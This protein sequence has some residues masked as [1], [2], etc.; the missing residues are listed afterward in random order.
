MVSGMKI[1]AWATV[2]WIAGLLTGGTALAANVSRSGDVTFHKDVLPILQKNC[3]N[4]HRPGQI[5][6]MPLLTYDE[7]RPWAKAIKAAVL[8]H[9][10]P[11][12]FADPQYGHFSNDRTLKPQE[13]ATLVKWVDGGAVAGDPKDAPAPVAWP[14]EGWRIKPDH[15]VKGVAYHVPKSGV[16]PWMYVTV[17]VGFNE[18]TWVTSMEM[19]PGSKPALTHH[20]CIFLVPHRD[21]VQYGVFNETGMLGQAAAT[22]NAPF[23]GCYEKGQEEFDYRPQHAGRLIPANM[24]MVFQMHYQPNGEEAIDLPQV[25][26]TV[27][28]ERP[29]RQYVFFNVGAGLRL[30]IPPNEANYIAPAQE[31]EL[32]VDGE[33]VWLQ[34]HA[35][36]RAKEMKFDILYPDGR[37]ETALRVNW[38]PYW[39]TIYYPS[40]PIVVPK[41]TRLH[42]EGRYDN[43]ANNPYNPDPNA[44]VHFGDQGKDEMMF[45][46]FGVIVDGS[47]DLTK[48]QVLKP[49]PRAG[50]DFII[51]ES[52]SSQ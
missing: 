44:L 23:E 4:C 42:I 31:G 5:G 7:T 45:P 48:T 52:A 3:Q 17:P 26:F 27:S 22:G 9:K 24:D 37:D 36:Y 47:L 19:R 18:D 28:K 51:A 20:Y 40:Q 13:I 43:S 49:S 8:N 38:D 34:A 21:G 1:R 35:H 25:G 29:S 33:I 46:T 14:E 11:P 39:Q 10:M 12:W 2:I 50:P 15:I 16:M 30:N 32:E 41:G 6:K